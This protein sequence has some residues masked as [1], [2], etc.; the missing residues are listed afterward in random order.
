DEDQNVIGD[1][2]YLLNE[3]ERLI[4]E[5][6][7]VRL[8]SKRESIADDIASKSM[9]SFMSES[10]TSI[11]KNRVDRIIKNALKDDEDSHFFQELLSLIST[12]SSLSLEKC[13]KETP[14]S[15][16]AVLI[17]LIKTNFL[18]L[19]EKE[20][21]FSSLN[22]HLYL[23][24]IL[25]PH[26]RKEF[27][28]RN[29][30][31]ISNVLVKIHDMVSNNKLFYQN[32]ISI[33][34][35]LF[36]TLTQK[37]YE[38]D[39]NCPKLFDIFLMYLNESKT[40]E[41][42][43]HLV[44]KMF[45]ETSSIFCRSTILLKTI[46]NLSDESLKSKDIAFCLTIINQ[47]LDS[48]FDLKILKPL[49]E[50]MFK[51]FDSNNFNLNQAVCE[52]I[53]KAIE[54]FKNNSSTDIFFTSL[55]LK[56]SKFVFSLNMDNASKFKLQLTLLK[57][58]ATNKSKEQ[59]QLVLNLIDKTSIELE[60]DETT[61]ES[62][63]AQLSDTFKMIYIQHD[64][65][66]KSKDRLINFIETVH[67]MLIQDTE[68]FFKVLLS[69]NLI[70]SLAKSNED[71]AA[72][73]STNYIEKIFDYFLTKEKQS[74]KYTQS[75]VS[76]CLNFL[77]QKFP[78]KNPF[79]LFF[80]K[81]NE[82]E[83]S[84]LWLLDKIVSTAHQ[85]YQIDFYFECCIP[86]IEFLEQN[87]SN[88]ISEE[89]TEKINNCIDALWNF[90][91]SFC[92]GK[93]I[94]DYHI[95]IIMRIFQSINFLYL[96]NFLAGIRKLILNSSDQQNFLKDLSNLLYEDY[97]KNDKQL[98]LKEIN[99]SRNSIIE[100]FNSIFKVFDDA[101]LEYVYQSL[102]SLLFQD[103]NDQS[104]EYTLYIN[105][106]VC[107][108]IKTNSNYFSTYKPIALKMIEN[109][110]DRLKR[111]G[112][113]VLSTFYGNSDLEKK[114][115]SFESEKK[116]LEPL[117]QKINDNTVRHQIH[118]LNTIFASTLITESSISSAINWIMPFIKKII[119]STNARSR[120][121]AHYSKSLIQTIIT[122]ILKIDDTKDGHIKEFINMLI[123]SQN[124]DKTTASSILKCLQ[125]IFQSHATIFTSDIYWKIIDIIEGSY[126]SNLS[127]FALNSLL[128]FS[129]MAVNQL[130]IEDLPHFWE[131]IN[132]KIK[133]NLNILPKDSKEL[134]KLFKSTLN[135]IS[136]DDLDSFLC[137]DLKKCLKR[138]ISK[139]D[140]ISVQSDFTAISVQNPE[141][142]ETKAEKTIAKIPRKMLRKIENDSD[143]YTGDEEILDFTSKT[144]SKNNL[145]KDIQVNDDKTVV[146]GRE[147]I[148]NNKSS[149]RK[150][151]SASKK[152]THITLNSSD[153]SRKKSKMKPGIF[154]HL[155]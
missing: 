49:F 140:G 28:A 53:T 126:G 47:A 81:N 34:T 113:K 76:K 38:S 43:Q 88:D 109:A 52:T 117:F 143:E 130:Q 132:T 153:L 21:D 86:F 136:Q 13:G 1:I 107:M 70:M 144:F 115:I 79:E 39:K 20:S 18:N 54:K 3:N 78:S 31:Q 101:N 50:V 150:K 24:K 42:I 6:S 87:L 11:L 92:S 62:I 14:Y 131:F 75:I 108:I 73:L 124:S 22:H 68:D 33:V 27:L 12:C 58:L 127:P 134:F 135:L 91:P 123:S 37:V 119:I 137:F 110:D 59:F 120:K 111:A 112:L 44:R 77:A 100:T 146:L 139:R 128:E 103:G 84:R 102:T 36:Q 149:K 129:S 67:E 116:F 72:Q 8:T 4:E 32:Y 19:E 69:L 105:D 48:E 142:K 95:E 145:I 35:S 154:D 61:Y 26:V 89:S 83:H 5:K 85:N 125:I 114:E 30:S 7:G 45:S 141:K 122:M 152:S 147:N 151:N 104:I 82:L 2:G 10:A 74:S 60:I 9:L 121:T 57:Y 94:M 25:L 23:M 41:N 99:I 133:N 51:I 80:I 63:V 40:D 16:I 66:N 71:I 17:M 65:D 106:I 138:Y 118:I 96:L 46:K 55:A 56:L 64:I 97:I 98:S 93:K 29:A 148:L 90:F 155:F 15:F